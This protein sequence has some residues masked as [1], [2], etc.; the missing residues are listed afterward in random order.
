ME[1]HQSNGDATEVIFAGTIRVMADELR[2][3]DGDLVQA[4]QNLVGHTGAQV[5]EART[6]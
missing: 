2:E 3:A 5:I 1:R 6:R 4:V